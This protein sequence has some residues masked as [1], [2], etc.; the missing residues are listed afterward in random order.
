M[1]WRTSGC[2][3]IVTLSLSLFLGGRIGVPGRQWMPW[4]APRHMVRLIAYIANPR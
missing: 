1:L 4:I 3:S 2:R